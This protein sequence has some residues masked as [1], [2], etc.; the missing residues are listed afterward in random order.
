MNIKYKKGSPSMELENQ[1][2]APYFYYPRLREYDFIKHG[3]STR[4][5][6]VSE[7]ECTSM[8]LS[9]AREKSVENVKENYNRICKSI[10]VNPD[11][12]AFSNQIHSNKIAVVTKDNYSSYNHVYK[13]A[14]GLITNVQGICLVTMYADCVP[15]Y[16]VDPRKKA[17]GLSHAGWR[18]TVDKISVETVVAMKQKYDSKPEDII[19]AIGPSICQECYE[20]SEDVIR[21]VQKEFDQSLWSRI[22]FKN[23]TDKYQLNLWEA[24]KAS[25][26]E[27]GILEENIII[28]NVCTCCNSELLFS[29][30]A[31]QGKRGN[32]AAFL[33]MKEEE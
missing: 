8:N 13:N 32:L 22:Y 28:T 19:V 11:K 6:G 25:L 21:E 7:D 30:R 14:D 2:G 10:G 33:S 5:G 15:L 9:Y 1:Q 4:L 24:N 18:G 26:M 31:S 23:S 16:F 20:V 29:H 17:I 27:S 3:F 12:L